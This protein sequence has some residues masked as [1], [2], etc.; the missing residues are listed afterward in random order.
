MKKGGKGVPGRGNL[1]HLLPPPHANKN[2]RSEVSS[3]GR[4]GRPRQPPGHG[5]DIPPS[6]RGRWA[7]DGAPAGRGVFEKIKNKH[8]KPQYTQNLHL[9]RGQ[10]H[11]QQY[12]GVGGAGAG[13][14]L[15]LGRGP[16]HLAGGGSETG[17]T[18][19]TLSRV[20]GAVG[21]FSVAGH[22]AGT[23]NQ[24]EPDS[25]AHPPLRPLTL[26]LFIHSRPPAEEETPEDGRCECAGRPPPLRGAQAGK[27]GTCARP[28]RPGAQQRLQEAPRAGVGRSAFMVKGA[29]TCA[30]RVT[31]GRWR[32]TK[33]L[34]PHSSSCWSFPGSHWAGVRS[35]HLSG[36]LGLGTVGSNMCCA[37]DL[38][39]V[40]RGRPPAQAWCP[41][42]A[43]RR[44]VRHGGALERGEAGTTPL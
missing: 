42:P 18:S 38:S 3:D 7:P 24:E 5:S 11:G 23:Q 13:W 30:H 34:V 44:H 10:D 8:Q 14:A 26:G 41:A 28:W 43:R 29:G 36:T 12:R 19:V 31:S 33:G 1:A 35:S 15:G 22:G 17:G 40:S 32:L 37:L 25:S 20:P 27:G 4:F 39:F 2:L 6:P 16:P 9:S 21:L